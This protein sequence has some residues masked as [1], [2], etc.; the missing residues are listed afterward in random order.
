[1]F[2]HF[3]YFKPQDPDPDFESG[4]RRPLNPDPKHGPKIRHCR[5]LFRI[6]TCDARPCMMKFS[7]VP[8]NSYSRFFIMLHHWC[9]KGF[10]YFGSLRIF[11]FH[12]WYWHV[13][14]SGS[15][16]QCLCF[17]GVCSSLDCC[18]AENR[19]QQIFHIN[20]YF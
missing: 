7:E 11:F 2:Q 1:M 9:K 18:A 20:K 10:S 5:G 8:K 4:S 15:L 17:M 3:K 19:N 16:H 6:V 12:R 14:F 13:K